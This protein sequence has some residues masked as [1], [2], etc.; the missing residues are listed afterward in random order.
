MCEWRKTSHY[1]IVISPHYCHSCIF[2]WILWALK[3][4]CHSLL[5]NQFII[6][7]HSLWKDHEKKKTQ[8]KMEWWFVCQI[9]WWQRLKIYFKLFKNTKLNAGEWIF[10]CGFFSIFQFFN[11]SSFLYLT[12]Y[13]WNDISHIMLKWEDY[14]LEN[15]RV[16]IYNEIMMNHELQDFA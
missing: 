11:F 16:K 4:I 3:S 13:K 14:T 5:K 2:F 8:E 15:S 9:W 1:F 6:F 12:K 10:F 7:F